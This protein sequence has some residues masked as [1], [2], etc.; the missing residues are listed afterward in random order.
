MGSKMSFTLR[1][2]GLSLGVALFG[3]FTAWQAAAQVPSYSA[4]YVFGDSLTDVGNVY[5]VAAFALPVSPPYMPGRFSNGP[6]WAEDVASALA[7]SAST[8]SILGGTNYSYG[9][10]N[11]TSQIHSPTYYPI[12]TQGQY[13]FFSQNMKNKAPSTALYLMWAGGVDMKN[14]ASSIY[15]T[16][17]SLLLTANST[18]ASIGS[19]LRNLIGI[20]ARHIAVLNLPDMSTIPASATLA[21][22]LK[23]NRQYA[24]L[25]FNQAIAQQVAALNG[26]NGAHVVLVDTYTLFQQMEA[27]PAAYGFTNASA[28]CWPSGDQAT[29]PGWMCSTNYNLQNQ[30]LFWDTVHPTASGHQFI[31][32]LVLSQLP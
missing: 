7:L 30:Y 2:T 10:A 9:G 17:D 6:V 18:A 23:Q 5:N 4:E 15:A 24:S 29:K 31:A 27:S 21:A 13:Y 1:R 26:L 25:A 3:L 19:T 28:A 14:A 20:G 22:N 11:T 32:N 16:T 8:P 12:G